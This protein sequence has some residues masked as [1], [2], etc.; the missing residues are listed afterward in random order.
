MA[1]SRFILG[2]MSI[3]DFTRRSQIR[4]GVLVVDAAVGQS[5][6]KISASLK[7]TFWKQGKT[8]CVLR[9]T[10]ALIKQEDG[11]WLRT[12]I[13]HVRLRGHPTQSNPSGLFLGNDTFEELAQTPKGETRVA[14]LNGKVKGAMAQALAQLQYAF[15]MV[16]KVPTVQVE[17]FIAEEEGG[18]WGEGAFLII[19]VSGV[20][21]EL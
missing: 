13:M 1:G 8:H 15:A 11:R 7:A 18:Y 3:S 10:K 14:V 9:S 19:G 17:H 4:E 5:S 12:V 20:A 6:Q 16:G 21:A 2:D